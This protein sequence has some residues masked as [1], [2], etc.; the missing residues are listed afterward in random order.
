MGRAGKPGRGVGWRLVRTE[1]WGTR[2][3]LRQKVKQEA[4]PGGRDVRQHR[5]AERESELPLRKCAD[6]RA[7]ASSPP[8]LPSEG[9]TGGL[10]ADPG[11][12]VRLQCE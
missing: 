9:H 4:L 3:G 8:M 7:G 1:R 10:R 12:L 6:N 2:L 11:G 5:R